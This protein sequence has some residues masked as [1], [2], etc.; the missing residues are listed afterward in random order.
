[1]VQLNGLL[2]KGIGGFYYVEAAD[3][4]YECR[5]RGIFRKRRQAPLV[6]D[7]VRITVDEAGRENTIDEIL[8]RKNFLRRPPL[9]NLEQL[10]LVASSCEPSPNLFLLDKLTAIA[11]SKQIAPV[12]VFTKTDLCNADAFIGIYRQAGI[13]AF[14]VSC[15][16]GEGVEAFRPILAGKLSAFTGNSGVGKSS[17]LNCLDASLRLPT[18]EISDKLGRGRHTTRQSEI[19]HLAG[20]LVADTPGFSSLDLEKS[21]VLRKEELP[22]C[23]PEFLPYLGQCRFSSCTHTRDRGCAILRAVEAGEIG[24]Q[25]HESY[26]SLYE[27]AKSVKEWELDERGR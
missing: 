22:F 26:V 23:F 25:R 13:P 12:M 17:L 20:G 6:G 1:M 19:F 24:R 10:I 15:K 11:V 14:S 2:Q 4:V 8:P 16:T 18:G 21:E 7:K 3:T 5:A 27:E 9:A